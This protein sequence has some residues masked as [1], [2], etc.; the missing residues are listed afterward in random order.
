MLPNSKISKK[1]GV[2]K[3]KLLTCGVEGELKN[4]F[5]IYKYDL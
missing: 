1:V 2:I 3:S 5:R 4:E